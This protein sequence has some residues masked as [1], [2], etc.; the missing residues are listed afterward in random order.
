MKKLIDVYWTA[1][2][3][4]VIEVDIPDYAFEDDQE[5]KDV[6]ADECCNIDPEFNNSNCYVSDSFEVQYWKYLD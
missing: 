2:Y 4:T 5:A 6:V 1:E 3:S